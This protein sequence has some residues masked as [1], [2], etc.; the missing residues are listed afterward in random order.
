MY[1]VQTILVDTNTGHGVQIPQLTGQS[2]TS[3][4][5]NLIVNSSLTFNEVYSAIITTISDDEKINSIGNVEFS[6]S[7]ISMGNI[8]Q[9]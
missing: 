7:C 1:K 6:M 2:G 5:L 8:Y 9:N 4:Q 3:L